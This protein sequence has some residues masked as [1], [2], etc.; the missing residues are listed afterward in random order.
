MNY[1]HGTSSERFIT[2]QQL[3][4]TMS[5]NGYE[6]FRRNVKTNQMSERF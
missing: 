6:R 5:P 3:E 4:G 1:A 2:V